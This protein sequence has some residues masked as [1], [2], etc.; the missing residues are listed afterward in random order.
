M[1]GLWLY[2]GALSELERHLN[3]RRELSLRKAEHS[4]FSFFTL[5]CELNVRLRK[6]TQ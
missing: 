3:I 6:Q 1:E 5:G 2:L 4:M